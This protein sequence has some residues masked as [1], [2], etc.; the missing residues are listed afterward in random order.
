MSLLAVLGSSAMTIVPRPGAESA[1]DQMMLVA[2]A[3]F[4]AWLCVAFWV[5]MRQR[6]ASQ[7]VLPH[8]LRWLLMFVGVVYLLAVFLLVIG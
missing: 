1:R 7:P 8:W 4:V 6:A 3:F 5:R 2:G